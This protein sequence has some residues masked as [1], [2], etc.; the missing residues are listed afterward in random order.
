MDWP[1]EFNGNVVYVQ[2]DTQDQAARAFDAIAKAC[3]HLYVEDVVATLGVM[4]PV[5]GRPD[6][7]AVRERLLALGL[8]SRVPHLPEVERL[9]PLGWKAAG[10][11]LVATVGDSVF[12]L[13]GCR[14]YRVGRPKEFHLSRRTA[15]SNQSSFDDRLDVL[16]NEGKTWLW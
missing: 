8:R 13:D 16:L 5:L 4:A 7:E 11:S 3:E 9:W 15:N 1:F 6:P 10:N 12:R 14:Q 2:G